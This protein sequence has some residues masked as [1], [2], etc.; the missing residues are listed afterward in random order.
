MSSVG[1]GAKRLN[2]C[3]QQCAEED[4]RSIFVENHEFRTLFIDGCKF[5]MR[6]FKPATVVHLNYKRLE[7]TGQKALAKSGT[8][9]EASIVRIM[10]ASTGLPFAACPKTGYS[11][12]KRS[13][14]N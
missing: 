6:H 12:V 2:G 8:Q 4:T 10:L 5:R 7:G 9:H 1:G 11:P 13:Q 14:N 3:N